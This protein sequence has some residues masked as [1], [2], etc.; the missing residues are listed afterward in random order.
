MTLQL[1]IESESVVSRE[2]QR[3]CSKRPAN[4]VAILAYSCRD[5]SDSSLLES[6]NDVGN[7]A[8]ISEI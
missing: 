7:H 5:L 2:S 1:P 4:D 6:W 3:A 8:L